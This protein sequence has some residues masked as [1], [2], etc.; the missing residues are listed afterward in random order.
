MTTALLDSPL[1]LYWCKANLYLALFYGF[2]WLLLRRHT[3]LSLN[4]VYLLASVVVAWLLPLVNIPGLAWAWPWGTEEPVVTAVAAD[5]GTVMAVAVAPEAP[6][7]PDWPTLALWLAGAVALGLLIRTGWRTGALLRLIRQWPAQVLPTYTLVHPTDAQTP[8]FSFFRYLVL[9]PDDAHTEAVRQHELVHIR[10]RHSVD[11]LLMDVL[12]ALCWP[13]PVLFGYRRAIRQVHEFLA[14]RDALTQAATDRDTYA[15]FL[16]DYAFHLP[17]RGTETAPDG[18]THSFGPAQPE[19]PTLKQRIQ[20]LYQQ[21]TNRRALWKYALIMPLATALL[22]MTTRP[23]AST[24]VATT[25]TVTSGIAPT[26]ATITASIDTVLIEGRVIDRATRKPLPGANIVIKND[27]RGTTANAEGNFKINLPNDKPVTLVASFVGFRSEEREI[28]ANGRHIIL[29]VALASETADVSSVPMTSPPSTATAPIGSENEVFTVVEQQPVFPGGMQALTKFLDDNIQYPDAARRAQVSG[30]VFVQ[31]VVNTDGSLGDLQI[32]KGLGFGCD[33]EAIRLM[34]AMPNWVPGRQSGK[35]VTVRYNLPINFQLSDKKSG[36]V[37]PTPNRQS[38][39]SFPGGESALLSFL[40]KTIHYP[41][42]AIKAN[43]DGTSL[44]EMIVNEDGSLSN[45]QVL[46]SIGFGID[47]EA[48]R[49]V[50]QM[51]KWNPALENGKPV[52][53]KYVLP[54]RFQLDDK[55]TG[56]VP[57]PDPIQVGVY[58]FPRIGLSSLATT[59]NK[60]E[61]TTS[62]HVINRT[63]AIGDGREPLFIIN[64]KKADKATMPALDPNTIESVTVLKDSYARNKYKEY[65]DEA[66]YGVV[67]ITLKKKERKE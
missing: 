67:E 63:N 11:V 53:V 23:E 40:I 37:A 60:A 3:F 41:K 6:L 61:S 49:I 8:T 26:E 4:R 32:L 50:K 28:K 10:Q 25:A 33:A 55:K 42:R 56:Y 59:S 21:H 20:M 12:Q 17:S 27:T 24:E 7:L 34:K 29:L 1:L 52:A 65:G 57:T 19:S 31:F 45:I 44:I 43:I 18:L 38:A 39:P 5:L 54:I 14:D 30:K 66:R 15:R 13:N 62:F 58:S 47:E 48:V 2:Y 36:Y 46:K 51:P 9:N 22:A 16:L 64:G 35:P